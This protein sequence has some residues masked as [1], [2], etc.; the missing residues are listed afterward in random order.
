MVRTSLVVVV[1]GVG[2]GCVEPLD[3]P[4]Y[5]V[6][7]AYGLVAEAQGVIPGPF[8][9]FAGRIALVR[10][11]FG[12]PRSRPDFVDGVTPP[13]CLGFVLDPNRP[14]GGNALEAGTMR[15]DGLREATVSDLANLA[16]GVPVDVPGS[17]RCFPTEDSF[18]A[19]GETGV[20][21]QCE[22]PRVGVLNTPARLIDPGGEVVISVSGGA[23]IAPFRSR[24]LR[25]PPV[26]T[27]AGSFDL[28]AVNPASIVAEW[29]P[30]E[31]PL[32]LIEIIAQRSDGSAGAQILC[33]EP[34][35]SAQKAL[36]TGALALIPS[37][38]DATPLL[39]ITTIAAV[40][41]ESSRDEGWGGYLVGVGRGSMGV[42]CRGAAGPCPP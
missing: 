34:M 38:T 8:G 13:N 21:Y 41:F 14:P 5:G 4:A 2:A 37:P 20:R 29:M 26:L 42:S 31:A 3:V 22:M 16:N 10:S 6:Y 25:A 19:P 30:A 15:F 24:G 17:T 36:P 12:G 18:R 7:Q 33:L 39:I 23:D 11:A 9:P 28:T 27:A 40:N 35:P 32:V 1:S